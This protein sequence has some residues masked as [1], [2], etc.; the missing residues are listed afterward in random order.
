M[1]D[2][3]K[4]LKENFS[5]NRYVIVGLFVAWIAIVAFTLYSY[6]D[7]LGKQS[8]GNEFYDNYVELTSGTLICETVPVEEGADTVAVKMATYA[9]KNS[10]NINITVTGTKS[11]KVYADK[12]INVKNVLDN[13]FVTVALDEELS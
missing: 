9:R 10:G 6:R 7:T 1:K 8:S 4:R 12:T 3:G 13:T 5:K 2:L 11:G